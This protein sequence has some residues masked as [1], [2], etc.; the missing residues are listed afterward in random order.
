MVVLAVA[1]S[2]AT[3]EMALRY[4]RHFTMHNDGMVT[5]E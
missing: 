3:P 1:A 2:R 4:G 5:P